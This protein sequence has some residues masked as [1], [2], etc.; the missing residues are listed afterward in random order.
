MVKINPEYEILEL[1]LV[2]SDRCPESRTSSQSLPRD[3]ERQSQN[4]PP[5]GH[6]P[7]AVL[8]VCPVGGTG[9]D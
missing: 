6:A 7:K 9:R 2:E 1:I 3:S 5:P 4:G 8:G